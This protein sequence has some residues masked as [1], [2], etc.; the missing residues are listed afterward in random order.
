MA[1]GMVFEFDAGQLWTWRVK[2]FTW[3][4]S[5][6]PYHLPMQSLQTPAIS[7]KL[8]CYLMLLV[9]QF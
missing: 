9:C 7:I 3:A 5:A 1:S 8:L 4:K 6:R 2:Q